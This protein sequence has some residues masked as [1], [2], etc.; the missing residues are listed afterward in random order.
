MSPEQARGRSV[1]ARSDIFS[2]GVVLYEV[3]AGRA[4]FA[5][6]SS[7]DVLAA[8][9][10]REPPPLARFADDIPQELQ[11]IVECLRKSE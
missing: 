3:V 4:P 8:I 6:E 10:D 1:D 2:L 11:R 9:L 5:G 7:T